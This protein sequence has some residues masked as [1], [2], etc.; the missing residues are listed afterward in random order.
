MAEH[1]LRISRRTFLAGSG[2]GVV[3]A[4]LPGGFM[5]GAVAAGPADWAVR[6]PAPFPE[7][8]WLKSNQR[9]CFGV[10]AA[11][12]DEVVKAGTNVI[13][14]GTNAAGIGFAGG[15]FILGKN[16]EFVDIRSGAAIPERTLAELRARV[17]AAHAK[18][19]KV[20]GEVIRFYMT[21]WLQAEHPDWQDIASPGGKPISVAELKDNAV[22]GCWNSPYGDWFIKSQVA[23]VKRLDWDGYNMDGFGCWTHCFCPYCEKAFRQDMGQDIPASSDVNDRGFRHYL[24][25]RLDRYT[26]FVRKWT[27]ALKAVKPDFV[28]APW[29]TGPGRWW[30]WM[31]APAAEGTD[32]LHRVLD[33]PFLELLWDFPPDQGS[34]LLP[35]FTCRYYRGLTG[36]RPAWILPY[37]C[38]QGQFNAQPP[39]AECDVREMTVL[40]NGDLVAQGYWQQ[41][42]DASL[43]HFNR[44]LELREPFTT[45]A[46]SLKWA[47]MF[48]G[49]SSRLL[50]GLPGVRSEVPLGAWMGSGVDSPRMGALP[51]GERRMPAHME[52]AVGVF[53]AMMEDHLPLDIIIEPDLEDAKTLGQYKVLILPNAACLSRRAVDSIR[54]FVR[55]GGGLVALHESSLCN[56]FGDRADDF[57]LA[58]VFG[59][60]F[61]GTE[62]FSARWP[63]YPKWVELYLGV[64]GPDL[65]PIY[66]D[67]VVR[68]NYRRGSDRLQYIGWMTN[69]EVAPGATAKGRRLSAPKEW[70]LLVL[71]QPGQGKSVYFAADMGQ[72]YFIAP[73]QYQRRLLSNAVKWAAGVNQ[74]PVRVEAPLC[75][76]AAFYTQQEGRRT[77]V[78][79]LNEAN[80]SANRALPFNNPSEREETLPVFDIKVTFHGPA[81]ARVFQEPEHLPLPLRKVG[82]GVEVTVP[83]L[84]VHSM[85]V[86]SDRSLW[87]GA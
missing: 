8:T 31:G 18:Q 6:F 85:V 40:T 2:A 84:E 30:H 77:V 72:A 64:V 66:D 58:D 80:T 86:A 39:R 47:A 42:Q 61:L 49:E 48:V 87:R 14:G 3:L 19:A 55:G 69:V 36:D 51:A 41:S 38:E 68:S 33:A 74:P 10:D 59:V 81:V 65:H 11:S 45:G 53:R 52:S 28:T 62:D 44:A 70:P 13:C 82:D 67:P 32:A 73:Y 37:L 63:N 78:H 15:P 50:Y 9:L 23:L 4:A 12:L 20:L 25:W 76:Q 35:A 24:K 43:A 21:P 56:E 7:T 29:T 79:L 60:C 75:V 16:E 27:A 71:N 5:N 1:D 57:G 26:H 83:R 17:D 22:L 54:A 34:N 46:R